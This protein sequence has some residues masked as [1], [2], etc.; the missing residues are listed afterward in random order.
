VRDPDLAIMREIV[1]HGKRL[2]GID[3]SKRWLD[4]ST[5]GTKRIERVSNTA[6]QVVAFVDSL[7]AA[8]DVVVFERTGGYERLLETVLAEKGVAWALVHSQRV[9]AF[10]LALGIK[11][12]TDAIDCR[13]LRD[14]G[15]N[16]LDAGALRFGRA[17]DVTLHSLLARQRQLT[18]MLHAERCRLAMAAHD[19]V[20]ASIELLIG[21]LDAALSII[22][23]E[24]AAHE[25]QDIQLRR[26]QDILCRE[27]GVGGATAR[28]L[29]ADLPELGHLKSKEVVSLAALASRVHE[30]GTLRCRG[31]L[32]P[33]R[34]C[35][36]KALYFPAL[37]AMRFDPDLAAF[38]KRLRERGKPKMVVVVAV[39]RK[40]LVRLNARLRDALATE[41][42]NQAAAPAAG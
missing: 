41:D 36:R 35:V 22:E 25:A 30:S 13:V 34:G 26:K 37:T 32:A 28:A 18:A 10:R 12:K 33:G 27:V 39:M 1:M 5:E 21:Q 31:G 8:H 16:R 11:A 40:L 6:D 29:L 17:S 14:Y 24:L 19:A 4:V 2:I 7:D 20:R 3:V 38:A 15:R 9:K 23:A 42:G